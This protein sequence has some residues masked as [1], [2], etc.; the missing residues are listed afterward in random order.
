MTRCWKTYRALCRKTCNFVGNFF[1]EIYF[2]WKQENIIFSGQISSA[3]SNNSNY[4]SLLPTVKT[5]TDIDS[6]CLAASTSNS[7]RAAISLAPSFSIRTQSLV[8]SVSIVTI[9]KCNNNKQQFSCVHVFLKIIYG[10]Q[11]FTTFWSNQQIKK[12]KKTSMY[13]LP[14]HASRWHHLFKW[15]LCVGKNTIS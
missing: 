14:V 2:H 5:M 12:Y 8:N 13:L 11:L 6:T 1:V 15:L 9:Y 3:G 10:E 7:P 4:N